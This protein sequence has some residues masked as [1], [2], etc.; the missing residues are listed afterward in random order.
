MKKEAVRAKNLIKIPLMTM[1]E[2]TPDGFRAKVL[3]NRMPKTKPIA[4]INDIIYWKDGS[5]ER[6]AVVTGIRISVN[7]MEW[8]YE[9]VTMRLSDGYTD[10]GGIRENKIKVFKE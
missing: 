10:S 1:Q 4:N 9:Y 5:V 3:V 6:Y 8:F 2:I 7:E